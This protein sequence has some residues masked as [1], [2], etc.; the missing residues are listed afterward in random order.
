MKQ[1]QARF[2][3]TTA[4]YTLHPVDVDMHVYALQERV[5][6]DLAALDSLAKLAQKLHWVSIYVY[7]YNTLA[8]EV[9]AQQSACAT[10]KEYSI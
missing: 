7:V 9:G 6:C 4:L 2:S 8:E 5:L 3:V 10:Y 1:R